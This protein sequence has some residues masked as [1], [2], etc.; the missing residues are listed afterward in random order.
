VKATTT[1]RLGFTGRGEGIAAL[2]TILP[3]A[4]GLILRCLRGRRD[5]D[6]RERSAALARKQIECPA[7]Q[8]RDALDDRKPEAGAGD[9]AFVRAGD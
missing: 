2:A 8:A 9:V 6:A 7:V 5:H 3:G 4:A 1:E